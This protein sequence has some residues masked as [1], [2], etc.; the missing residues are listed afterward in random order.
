MIHHTP[1]LYCV[2]RGSDSPGIDPVW[3]PLIL[4]ELLPTLNLLAPSIRASSSAVR[5]GADGRSCG[6]GVVV[7]EV[8]ASLSGG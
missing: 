5:V 3:V 2:Y 8:D 4:S 1:R 6:G 7:C